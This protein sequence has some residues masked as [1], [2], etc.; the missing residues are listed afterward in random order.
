MRA[1]SSA[2]EPTGRS[3][4][5]LPYTIPRPQTSL[6]RPTRTKRPTVKWAWRPCPPGCHSGTHTYG[7]ASP[8]PAQT[9]EELAQIG[10]DLGLVETARPA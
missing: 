2:P 6:I 1:S 10:A 8:S 4:I 5:S 3:P 9:A 7:N